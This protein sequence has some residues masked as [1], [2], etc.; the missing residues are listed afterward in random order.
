MAT[1]AT[2]WL[3]AYSEALGIDPPTEDEV[4]QILALA[5][6]A[7]HASE[8]TAAPVACWLVAHAGVELGDARRLAEGVAENSTE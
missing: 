8:R 7:A 2:E 3:A 1:T 4:N 5:G 6:V